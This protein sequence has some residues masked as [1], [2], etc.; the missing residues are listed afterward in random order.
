MLNLRQAIHQ[1]APD[2]TDTGFTI[3]FNADTLVGNLGESLR[4]GGDDDDDTFENET[5]PSTD[6]ENDVGGQSSTLQ[7]YPSTSTIF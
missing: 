3:R 7:S 1:P 4:D 5:L 2:I 6:Q